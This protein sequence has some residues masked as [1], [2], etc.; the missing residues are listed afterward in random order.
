M[1][2]LYSISMLLACIF[3]TL[4]QSEIE[5][6]VNAQVW[7]PFVESWTKADADAFNALH[8]DDVLRVSA[9]GLRL[10]PEYKERNTASFERIQAS[11]DKRQ[12]QFWFEHRIYSGNHGYEVGYYKITV[13]RPGQDTRAYYA[14]FHVV[15]RKENGAWKIAQDWDTSNING[16][17]VSEEDWQK[18]T[19]LDF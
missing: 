18:G 2:Y 5:G 13:D 9:G 6:E 16:H 4:A 3:S 10:G 17:Q 11:N 15:L 12:I 1:K 19:P 7:G 14:R 8:T